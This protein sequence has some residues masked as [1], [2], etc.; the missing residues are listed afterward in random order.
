MDVDQCLLRYRNI[1]ER[2]TGRRHLAE[3]LS[4][5]QQYVRVLHTLRESGPDADADVAPIVRMAIVEQVLPA[6]PARDRE[7]IRFGVAAEAIARVRELPGVEAV[8]IEDATR[9]AE[10]VEKMAKAGAKLD[11]TDPVVNTVRTRARL[12][13]VSDEIMAKQAQQARD[14]A[15][16]EVDATRAGTTAT[17]AGV[18]QGDKKLD[19][20]AQNA[21]ADRQLSAEQMRAK[22]QAAA[23]KPAPGKRPPGRR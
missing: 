4:D 17:I 18:E 16:A 6:K 12:P 21:E 13:Q 2:V 14:M 7:P 19:M 15:M 11:P 5:H 20:D 10:M 3:P 1:E 8:S 23:K 9:I 22:E